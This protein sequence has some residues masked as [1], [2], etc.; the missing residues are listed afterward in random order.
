MIIIILPFSVSFAACGQLNPPR[1]RRKRPPFPTCPPYR[2]LT[3]RLLSSP[4]S[5]QFHGM[6]ND[7][8]SRVNFTKKGERERERERSRQTLK[9]RL[10]E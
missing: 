5:R 10:C 9:T 4:F 8:L 3:R 1:G 6:Q 2:E 7:S